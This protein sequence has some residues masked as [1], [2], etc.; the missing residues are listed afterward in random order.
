M[1]RVYRFPVRTSIYRSRIPRHISIPTLANGR[2]YPYCH[3]PLFIKYTLDEEL[4]NE[5]MEQL[6]SDWKNRDSKSLK[7]CVRIRLDL[8]EKK[9][10]KKILHT[11]VQHCSMPLPFMSKECGKKGTH[12]I[13]LYI[14]ST[15]SCDVD[16]TVESA[17][18]PLATYDV[19]GPK[20]KFN[21]SVMETTEVITHR[22]VNKNKEIIAGLFADNP[23][24]SVDTVSNEEVLTKN[25]SDLAAKQDREDL[26][27]GTKFVV[28]F[29]PQ[30]GDAVGSLVDALVD[31]TGG[32]PV[33]GGKWVE[34]GAK[35]LKLL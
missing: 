15:N 29:L 24:I 32:P 7:P 33:H 1:E 6:E 11:T 28:G 25:A 13:L 23:I 16:A 35:F 22:A 17:V 30:G 9:W 5:Q 18:L 10:T 12:L 8:H 20:A 31:S 34:V 3:R 27:A 21:F 4:S 26:K 2:R 19:D 14:T